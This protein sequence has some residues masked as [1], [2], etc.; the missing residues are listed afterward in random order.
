MTDPYY[1]RYTATQNRANPTAL[2]LRASPSSSQLPAKIRTSSTGRE[3]GNSG[4]SLASSATP[5]SSSSWLAYNNSSNQ[6]SI[7]VSDLHSLQQHQASGSTMTPSSLS[8]HSNSQNT[9]ASHTLSSASSTTVVNR[10]STGSNRYIV[11]GAN[12]MRKR[13]LL[14]LDVYSVLVLDGTSGGAFSHLCN[15][16]INAVDCVIVNMG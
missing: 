15:K 16:K 10:H 14:G 11:I 6:R 13:S 9:T 3:S 8:R 7:S 4:S 1:Q 5:T 12:N 2:V